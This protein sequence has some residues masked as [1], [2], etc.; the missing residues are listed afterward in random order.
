MF[1][2]QIR[3][4]M[5]RERVRAAAAAAAKAQQL[6]DARLYMVMWLRDHLRRVL[7]D[8]FTNAFTITFLRD[9]PVA[10]VVVNDKL[11]FLSF[12]A[13]PDSAYWDVWHESMRLYTLHV[14]E[15]GEHP[16]DT[17]LTFI[18]TAAGL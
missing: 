16:T 8:D 3:A 2:E 17:L 12:V 13:D 10:S 15:Y 1:E 6:E 11:V 18:G 4:A 14:E 5:E 7:G 9:R